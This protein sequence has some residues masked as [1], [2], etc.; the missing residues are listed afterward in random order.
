VSNENQPNDHIIIEL[1]STAQ[2]LTYGAI[3]NAIEK[4]SPGYI[5]TGLL[6][7]Q[8]TGNAIEIGITNKDDKGMEVAEAIGGIVGGIGATLFGLSTLPAAA[9]SYAVS[10]I[11]EDIYDT[12]TASKEEL[13]KAQNAP[14]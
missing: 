11:A 6:T 9:I 5:K 3:Y 14:D 7:M 4:T 12:F 8:Q 10:L 2:E 13:E 1:T